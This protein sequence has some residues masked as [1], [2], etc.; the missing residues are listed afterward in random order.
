MGYETHRRIGQKVCK[1]MPHLL[2]KEVS[3]DGK[4]FHIPVKKEIQE[5]V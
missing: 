4:G 3:F 5:G 2:R 1:D